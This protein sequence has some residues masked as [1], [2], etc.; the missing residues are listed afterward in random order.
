MPSSLYVVSEVS[1]EC[2]GSISPPEDGG[3][4]FL[5]NVGDH[6]ELHGVITQNTSSPP[7]KPQI[8]KEK[9]LY[10]MKK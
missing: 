4:R 2:V 1:E 6:L 5:Q 10:E 9:V 8:S 7:W 3:N